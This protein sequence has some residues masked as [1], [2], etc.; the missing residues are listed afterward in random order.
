M[1]RGKAAGLFFIV[2]S[3]LI[4]ILTQQVQIT[5]QHIAEPGPRLFPRIAAIGMILCS[6]GM[7]VVKTE[8]KEKEVYLNKNGWK[9]LAVVFSVVVLY[10]LG[11]AL[12]GFLAATP[13]ALLAFIAVLRSGKKVSW[14]MSGILSIVVTVGLFS[15][16]ESVFIIPL[17]AGILF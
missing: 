16:F 4:L 10:T 15:L 13:F 11:L 2:L 1:T 12:V 5:Q 9:K 6:V 7:L 3:V 14:V 8:S 17:P